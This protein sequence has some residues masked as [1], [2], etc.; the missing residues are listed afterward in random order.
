MPIISWAICISLTTT[1]SALLLDIS[2]GEFFVAQ[3][4]REYAD[5]LL[6]SFQPAEILFQR[7]PP[8]KFQRMVWHQGV[9]YCTG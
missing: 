5:K 4:D 9:H 6:Q 1:S 3:G 2:T 7:L 8:E